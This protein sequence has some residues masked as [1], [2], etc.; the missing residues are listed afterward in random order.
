MMKSWPT[1]ARV[2]AD[3]LDREAPAVLG[4]PPHSSVRLL[5]RGARNWLIRYPSRPMIS[6]PS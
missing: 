6:T 5:V 3:D 2:R 1:A 4:V